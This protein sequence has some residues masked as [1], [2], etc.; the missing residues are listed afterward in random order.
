MN[1]CRKFG[2]FSVP[3]LVV[4]IGAIAP[5][6]RIVI[7]C[8]GVCCMLPLYS[9]NVV[10]D[11]TEWYRNDGVTV[12]STYI[13]LGKSLSAGLTATKTGDGL[14]S[15]SCPVIDLMFCGNWVEAEAGDVASRETT[16]GLQ[17]DAYF[18]HSG[19]DDD[20]F[21]V[22]SF[23]VEADS[24]VYLMFTIITGGLGEEYE[25]P[26]YGWVELNLSDD[27][28]LSVGHSAWDLDGGA[29]VVGGG[30]ATPEPTSGVLLLFGVALL[31]LRRRPQ[32]V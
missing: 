11:A 20:D 2:F 9:A 27:G 6:K 23:S 3:G 12:I 19:I 7:C 28:V 8:L 5:L 24:D 31:G 17:R 10:W 26:V 14:Y 16:R 22:N 18:V 30:S 15:V 1:L 29:M 32:K 21:F 25:N 13:G 4:A